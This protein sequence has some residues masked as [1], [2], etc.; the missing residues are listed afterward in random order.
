MQRFF[1]GEVPY[2]AKGLEQEEGDGV[3]HIVDEPAEP[4]SVGG[5]SSGAH[6]WTRPGTSDVMELATSHR[7]GLLGY[8]TIA[9]PHCSAGRHNGK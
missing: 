8:E 5:A 2:R 7:C 3:A 1:Q 6:I 9:I 4:P